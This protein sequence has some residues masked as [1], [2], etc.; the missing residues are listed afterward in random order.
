M[1]GRPRKE[2][3]DATEPGFYHCY[4]RCVRRA[5]LCGE[6]T[7]AQ[8]NYDHR[9]DWIETRLKFLASQMAI[10]VTVTAVMGNH[11]HSI[12]KNRPDLVADWS[13]REVA[14]R[15]LRVCPGERQLNPSA[16]PIKPT[17]QQIDELLGDPVKL[18]KCRERLASL[19]WL[20]KLLKEPIAKC[21]NA[22]DD[23]KGTFWDGR[24]KSVRLLDIYSLVLCSLY[25][26]LNPIRAKQAKTP[27]TSLHTSVYWRIQARLARSTP[28]QQ[29]VKETDP[30]ADPLAA[31]W[32]TPIEEGAD[33]P[34]GPQSEQGRR[35][36]DQGFLPMSLE[37]YL[38]LVEGSGRQLKAG[39]RGV[40]PGDLPPILTRLNL[41]VDHWLEAIES[42]Q[43][44][45]G[46]FAGRPETLRA[47]AAKTGL[48]WIRGCGRVCN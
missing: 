25:V 2:I 20:M 43:D 27:E 17:K 30:P 14:V 22:E 37:K 13:E 5:F 48:R 11:F 29:E 36:T 40:I 33:P 8:K 47:H 16:P 28:A 44:C 41:P 1:P 10:E 19:S 26:D 18:A 21:A 31:S 38:V 39:K 35:A 9:K 12:I 4:S 24:F 46:D 32:L 45:F 6:D 42:F 7:Y 15:W 3:V 23:C 34:D